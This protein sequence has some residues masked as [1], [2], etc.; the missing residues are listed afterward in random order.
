MGLDQRGVGPV[1]AGD[2]LLEHVVLQ[3]QVPRRLRDE[4]VS[5]QHDDIENVQPPTCALGSE[6]KGTMLY[7]VRVLVSYERREKLCV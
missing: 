3:L 6:E 7:C 5:V 1:R 4:V 2:H